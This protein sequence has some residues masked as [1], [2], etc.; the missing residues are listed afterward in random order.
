MY[1]GTVL[2]THGGISNL[3]DFRQAFLDAAELAA[4]RIDEIIKHEEELN[5]AGML[6][7]SAHHWAK[8]AEALANASAITLDE[9][10]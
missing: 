2:T 8:A 6:G 9:A 1:I 5:S 4:T 7:E 10:V 3:P